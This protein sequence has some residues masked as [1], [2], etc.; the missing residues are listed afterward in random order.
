MTTNMKPEQEEVLKYPTDISSI[1]E[2]CA[3]IKW[4]GIE[5]TEYTDCA[6][7]YEVTFDQLRLMYD[8]GRQKESKLRAKDAEEIE[9]LKN[10]LYEQKE[11]TSRVRIE[12]M[13][14]LAQ[15]KE[16][17]TRLSQQVVDL[18]VIVMQ[19]KPRKD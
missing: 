15:Q 12:G 11:K 16:K 13:T 7:L 4:A 5:S 9:R 19:S 2:A 8:M 18:G 6:I 10:E 1:D 3:L 14:E 17:I